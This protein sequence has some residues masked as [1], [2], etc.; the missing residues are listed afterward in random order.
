MKTTLPT[1]ALVLETNNL[2][3]GD[4]DDPG[5]VVRSVARLFRRLREQT[6]SPASLAEV[7]LTHDGLGEAERRE[8]TCALGRPV[9]FVEVEPGTG[10]YEAKNR[11]A[12]AT[13]A[14]VVAFADTDCVPDPGWLRSL[15]SPFGDPGVQVVAGRTTYRDDVLGAAASAIDFMYFPA[16]GGADPASVAAR[17]RTRNFYA[18]N[19]AFRRDVF[20]RL[21][22]AAA[23]GI[24]RGHCQ[25]LGLALA[26]ARIPVRYVPE[27]HTVH[28]FP[29]SARELVR[30]RLLRGA[31]T[32]EMAPSFA[33]ALLPR[34]LRWVGR[35][36]PLSPLVVL[37]VRFALSQRALGHQ[38]MKALRGARRA[39]ARAAIAGISALDVAGALGR[40]VL[41]RDLGVRDGALVRDALSYHAERDGV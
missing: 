19:V 14:E 27:A 18:N 35:V 10:Y 15:L 2:R 38:D 3:G 25:R 26:A 12:D 21:R 37:G 36:G 28:R 1:C 5:R 24:Y 40:S 17:G 4:G 16:P 13:T 22:Y 39:A 41:R 6:R 7:V 23:P 34:P 31:D 20:A 8:L 9:H 30:L 11:G 32:A 33:D 29:D